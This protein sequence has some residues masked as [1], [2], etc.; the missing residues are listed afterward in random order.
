R[1]NANRIDDWRRSL[2]IEKKNMLLIVQRPRFEACKKRLTKQQL[3]SQWE[4]SSDDVFDG[5]IADL[6]RPNPENWQFRFR[7][8]SQKDRPL[9]DSVR[10]INRAGPHQRI[11][12]I[13]GYSHG[14]RAAIQCKI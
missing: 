12:N 7:T 8:I 14:R 3:S 9:A 2:R 4:D 6:Q 10:L 11:I 13:R 1:T 5:L